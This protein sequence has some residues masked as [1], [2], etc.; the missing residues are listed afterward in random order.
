M[1]KTKI[2][3]NGMGMRSGDQ[4]WRDAFNR[5]T[6]VADNYARTNHVENYAQYAGLIIYDRFTNR[7]LQTFQPQYN[8]I[9]QQIRRMAQAADSTQGWGS[10]MFDFSGNKV[11]TIRW[12]HTPA[13]NPATGAIISKREA[14]FV[15]PRDPGITIMSLPEEAANE[16]VATDCTVGEHF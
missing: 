16:E 10:H 13:V 11:C 6:H 7:H 1:Q 15:A 14:P 9:V 12:P 8:S 2:N 5:D 3:K 4:T